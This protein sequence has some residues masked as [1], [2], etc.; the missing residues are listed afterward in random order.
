MVLLTENKTIRN[1]Q[2]GNGMMTQKGNGKVIDTILRAK[3]PGERH[4]AMWKDGGLKVSSYTGPHTNLEA[5]LKDFKNNQPINKIDKTS[6]SHDI[7]Y[8]LAKTNADIAKA[9]QKMLQ[10]LDKLKG[11]NPIN[12]GIVKNAMKAKSF[13]EKKTGMTTFGKI[14][15]KAEPIDPVLE[16]LYKDRLAI[17]QQQGYGYSDNYNLFG[18][19]LQQQQGKGYSN[20]EDFK[21]IYKERHQQGK[22]VIKME[23]LVETEQGGNGL[24]TPSL[25]S[26]FSLF[27]F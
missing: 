11:E 20:F 16:K 9:D 27:K 25:G 22:G 24:F 12:M 17:Q 19:Y 21:K 13:F 15:P 14:D 6:L 18:R 23:D 7:S 8:A 1:I 10:T 3:Y 4:L 2:Y 5:R 26:M